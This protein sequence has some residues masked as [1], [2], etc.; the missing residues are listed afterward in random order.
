MFPVDLGR[1]RL[2]RNR[3][4]QSGQA[5]IYGIFLLIGGLAALFFFFNTG[6]LVREK[7]KLVNTA[8]AV[9]YSAGVMHARTLN[10]EAYANR[11]M[12]ANTV[13]IA[14]LVSLSSWIQYTNNLAQYGYAANNPKFVAFYPSYYLATMTGQY[15]QE[16]LNDSGVLENLAKASDK[17]NIALGAAQVAASDGLILVRAQVMKQVAEANYQDDGQVAL[18][19]VPLTGNS[20]GDFVQRYSGDDRTRFAKAANIAAHKD[21]FLKK[22]SWDLPALYSDCAGATV[23]GRVDWFDRRGGTELIGFDQWQAMDTL[24]EKRWT[25][26]DKFDVYCS[27][28]AETPTG[29]GETAAADSP[30]PDL[31]PSHYD[32]SLLIN[33]GPSVL[34]MITSQS[35]DYSGI[36]K[37]YDLSP[38][39]LGQADNDPRLKFAFRLRRSKMQTVTSEGRSQIKNTARLNTYKAQPAGG[40]ELVAVSASEAYFQRNTDNAYG[41]DTYGTPREI[42][43]LFNPF[44][45]ARLIQSD[46]E[47][48]KAQL[49]Q[50]VVVP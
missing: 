13:A 37:F 14:Q 6:Q 46:S 20:F 16:S 12:V 15:M 33:P 31:D 41:Q 44:W 22:R 43:S 9:A 1:G 29:W 48:R 5:L 34:A 30:T 2:G 28:L 17:L 27:A 26:S 32:Y 18:D 49:L 50:G 38:S 3:K 11:A 40:D 36:P 19:L 10:Y 21:G 42:G 45:Q 39:M 24:S 7:T 4:F 8:D 23:T 47:V 25:P 35:W